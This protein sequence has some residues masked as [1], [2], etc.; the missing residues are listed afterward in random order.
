MM[1]DISKSNSGDIGRPMGE[2]ELTDKIGR[3]RLGIS[4]GVDGLLW[5]A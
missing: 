2:E 5:I 3:H 1:G 4:M